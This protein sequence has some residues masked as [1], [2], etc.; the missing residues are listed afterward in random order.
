MLRE[1]ARRGASP[2]RGDISVIEIPKNISELLPYVPGKPVEELERELGLREIIKLASNENPLGGSPKGVEAARQALDS[3]QLYPDGS[4][5]RLKQKLAA[6]HQVAPEQIV[7]GN[8]SND[9]IEI[10]ARTLLTPGTTAVMFRHAFVV[11]PLVTGAAGA[12]LIEVPVEDRGGFRQEMDRLLAAIRP[13]TRIVFL[14][15]PNNPTGSMVGRTDFDAFVAKLPPHV[16]L[17]VDEAYAEYV[18]DP[19]Y[20]DPWPL[21]RSGRENIIVTRTFSKIYGLAGLRAG[22]GVTSAKLAGFLERV[23][24]PFNV[25]SC[26][27]AAAEA[28]LDD[29]G[30]VRRS[31]DLNTRGLQMLRDGCKRLGLEATPSWANFVLVRIPRP[32]KAVYEAMLREG[33]IVRPVGVYGLDEHLR[34]SVGEADQNIRCLKV[35]EEVLKRV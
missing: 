35:L 34:I 4:G 29:T 20:P 5:Y 3:V 19:D 16:L 25:N 23:R 32:P 1:A 22:Y 2:P 27:L 11:Y 18:T 15:N 9:V 21:V 12:G 24:Q 14:A 28:A 7:L 6:L 26:A 31:R 8:G 10:A 30:F 13:D 33:V 17:L